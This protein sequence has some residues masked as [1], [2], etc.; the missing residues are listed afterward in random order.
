MKKYLVLLILLFSWSF[1][2]FSVEPRGFLNNRVRRRL[3]MVGAY[4]MERQYKGIDT[5]YIQVPD[6]NWAVRGFTDFSGYSIRGNGVFE[7]RDYSV[8]LHT[9]FIVKQGFGVTWRSITV[10]ASFDLIGNPKNHFTVGLN[11]RGRK[12]G[13]EILYKRDKN[14]SGTQTFDGVVT[15][16]PVGSL[17]QMS[18]TADVCYVF[19]GEHFSYP[20]VFNQNRIQRRSA[21]SVIAAVSAN[22]FGTRSL[23]LTGNGSTPLSFGGFTMGIGAGYGYNFVAGRWTF[24]VSCIPS[25]VIIDRN[26]IALDGVEQRLNYQIFHFITTGNV[27][28]VYNHRQFFASLRVFFH[29]CTTGNAKE[30]KINYRRINGRLGLGWRF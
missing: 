11:S 30:L 26:R 23:L 10:A 2:A 3:N 17:N 20:A 18:L 1:T 22:L 12:L 28:V 13:Y 15:K 5:N 14:Y 25:L 27:A 19:N 16:F 4:M 9:P 21:G 29:N 24:H 8:D 7:G 6:K